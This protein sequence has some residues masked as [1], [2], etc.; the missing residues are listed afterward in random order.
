MSDKEPHWLIDTVLGQR[1]PA[2]MDMST[3]E[4]KQRNEFLERQQTRWRWMNARELRTFD[5]AHG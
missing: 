4:A 5:E 3:D 1:D 2:P